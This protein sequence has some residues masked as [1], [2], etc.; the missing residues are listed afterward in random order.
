MSARPEFSSS[1]HSS[2]DIM[3]TRCGP[4]A[5]ELPGRLKAPGPR[6]A[7]PPGSRRRAPAELAAVEEAPDAIRGHRFDDS[8][9]D[10][11]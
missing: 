6:V 7:T 4:P 8:F 1:L 5:T 9:W 2:S 11:G 10:S 3:S